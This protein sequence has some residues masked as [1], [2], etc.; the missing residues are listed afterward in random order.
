MTAKCE[1]ILVPLR[2]WDNQGLIVLDADGNRHRVLDSGSLYIVGKAGKLC[3][4]ALL[5][6]EEQERFL[7]R[8]KSGEELWIKLDCPH[9]HRLGA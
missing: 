6:T 3:G 1:T 4:E 7:V 9:E 8:F 5:L 2:S